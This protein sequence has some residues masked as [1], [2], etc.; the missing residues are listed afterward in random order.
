M[1]IDTAA[2]LMTGSGSK[3]TTTKDANRVKLTQFTHGL[4]CACKM[5]PQDLEQILHKIPLYEHP[6]ILVDCQELR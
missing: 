3:S 1:I 5:R 2:P 6:D 4:G